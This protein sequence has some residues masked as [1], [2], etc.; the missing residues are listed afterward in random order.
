MSVSAFNT[1][2]HKLTYQ[3]YLFN[4]YLSMLKQNGKLHPGKSVG[5]PMV[6]L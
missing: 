6:A 1:L 5:L 3:L 4:I 2:Y